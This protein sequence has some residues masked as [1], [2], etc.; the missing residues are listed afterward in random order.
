MIIVKHI[1]MVICTLVAMLYLLVLYI[2]KAP[3]KVPSY[4]PTISAVLTYRH[5]CYF[6]LII[7]WFKYLND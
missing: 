7:L 5:T 1:I 2:R 4:S 3:V 6:S